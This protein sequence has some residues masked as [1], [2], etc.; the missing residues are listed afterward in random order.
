MVNLKKWEEVDFFDIKLNDEIKGYIEVGPTFTHVVRGKVVYTQS[1]SDK[2]EGKI[3]LQR[4]WEKHNLARKR[5]I[6]KPEG[7]VLYRRKAK[8]FELPTEFGAIVSAVYVSRYTD[9]KRQWFVFDGED[10]CCGESAVS[11]T[12]LKEDYKDYILERDGITIP[13]S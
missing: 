5:E 11:P 13:T 1:T 2:K 4:D 10:W 7:T 9:G 8:P 3:S 12:D 6:G